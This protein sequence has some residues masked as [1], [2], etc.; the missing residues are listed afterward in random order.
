MQSGWQYLLLAFAVLWGLQIAGTALQMR[1]LR[2]VLA[3]LTERWN[4]GFI[5]T[6]AARARFGRGVIAILVTDRDGTVRESLVMQGRTVFAKF[7]AY[8][9]LAGRSIADI[10][11]G[12]VFRGK[13]ANL[14]TAFANCV[15][16]IERVAA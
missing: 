15:A 2:R 16:Q 5:G 13:G 10:K 7:R 4:D 8:P 11:S 9:P 12:D 6:G 1:H 14:A 3:S